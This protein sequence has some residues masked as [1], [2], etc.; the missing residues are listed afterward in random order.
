MAEKDL[1]DALVP[2]AYGGIPETV[3]TSVCAPDICLTEADDR[4]MVCAGSAWISFKLRDENED[5]RDR[6]LAQLR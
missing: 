2:E 3:R 4:R 1:N 6:N 5:K